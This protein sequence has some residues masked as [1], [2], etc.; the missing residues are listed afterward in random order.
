[1]HYPIYLADPNIGDHLHMASFFLVYSYSSNTQNYK[2]N[3]E[4]NLCS[5]CVHPAQMR[6]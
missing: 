4:V 1:M 2:Y 5:H 6:K 3:F